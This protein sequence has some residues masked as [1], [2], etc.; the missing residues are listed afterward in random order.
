M[1]EAENTDPT[2]KNNFP[3][4]LF[5]NKTLDEE[6]AGGPYKWAKEL[7]ESLKERG[8]PIETFRS[9]WKFLINGKTFKGLKKVNQTDIIQVYVSN[10]GILLLTLFG[11]IMKKEVIYSC[12]GNFFEEWKKTKNYWLFTKY[13][14]LAKMSNRITFPSEYMQK[15]I[16]KK[17]PNKPTEVLYTPVEKKKVKKETKKIK[18]KEYIFLQVTS[19]DYYKKGEGTI[20]LSKAFKKFNRIYKNSRLIIIGGGKHFEE[21][22]DKAKGKNII[23]LG[24][25]KRNKVN[26]HMKNCNCFIHITGLDNLPISILEAMSFHKPI[27][28]SNKFGIPEI[29]KDIYLT[30]NSVK[31]ILEKMLKVYESKEKERAYKDIQKFGKENAVNQFIKYYKKTFKS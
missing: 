13:Y 26:W 16:S 28:A 15:I 18:C 1:I 20:I 11:K 25:Q 14:L 4:V 6:K 9:N 27:I 5:L 12:R 21:I 2:K 19:F 30:K 31:E 17:F 29:S 8:Y 24:K 22:K 23:F 7:E 3:K 10:L